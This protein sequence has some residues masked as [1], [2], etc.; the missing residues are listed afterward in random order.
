MVLNEECLRKERNKMKKKERKK[1][2]MIKAVG[3]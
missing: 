1:K 3:W 2:E